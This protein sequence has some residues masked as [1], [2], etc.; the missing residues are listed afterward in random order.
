[1]DITTSSDCTGALADHPDSD[2]F[3]VLGYADGAVTRIP[4]DA[5]RDWRGR[6]VGDR[7]W[8]LEIGRGSFVNVDSTLRLGDPRQSLSIGS[9]TALGQRTRFLLGGVHRTNTAAIADFTSYGLRNPWPTVK[10][11]TI[12]IGHDVWGGDDVVFLPGCQ[13]ATGCVIGARTLVPMSMRTEPY[14]VYVGAPA[15]LV[16]FRFVESVRE[17]LLELAWWDL[18]LG[19]MRENNDLFMTDLAADEKQ[20]LEALAAMAE[21]K[22]AWLERA[23]TAVG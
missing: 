5:F 19:W 1:M 20:A 22:R 4:Q 16:S 18:P 13:V 7:P 8:R 9:W 3:L 12:R 11:D 15:R 10:D 21:A 14:G 17:A 23:A 2:V 6:D